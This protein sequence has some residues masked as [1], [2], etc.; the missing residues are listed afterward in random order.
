LKHQLC[1]PL[2]PKQNGVGHENLLLHSTQVRPK[3]ALFEDGV[4]VRCI[5]QKSCAQDKSKDM[6]GKLMRLLQLD[7]LSLF[8]NQRFHHLERHLLVQKNIQ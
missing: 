2:D 4:L 6:G 8:W 7:K 5:C 3:G 1:P